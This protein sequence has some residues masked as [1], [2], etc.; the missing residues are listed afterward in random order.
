[1]TFR[2]GSVWAAVAVDDNNEEGLVA[3]FLPQHGGW[4]PL[5]AA[6]EERLV[7]IKE[8][9]AR[10]AKQRQQL[11]RVIQLTSRV[12]LEAYDGRQ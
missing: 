3:E 8:T 11:V 12:E 6:D 4:V 7:W 9:A 2:I 5:V 10:L 1:M